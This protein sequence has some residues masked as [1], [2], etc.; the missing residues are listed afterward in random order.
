MPD[1]FSLYSPDICSL[2]TW[3]SHSLEFTHLAQMPVVPM[4]SPC[5][6]V[7]STPP[8][9]HHPARPGVFQSP[10]HLTPPQPSPS[11][12]PFVSRGINFLPASMAECE[13][14]APPTYHG[15]QQTK[16]VQTPG[17]TLWEGELSY[18]FQFQP[19]L[20][21]N[22]DTNFLP[23]KI[24]LACLMSCA[25]TSGPISAG[26]RRSYLCGW[27]VWQDNP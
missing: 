14:S 23:K 3:T 17:P 10:S 12:S 25:D 13:F 6:C 5:S 26:R 27:G 21:L 9:T 8:Q 22:L 18:K 19:L 4:S 11:L 7:I 24:W 2:S 1:F 15:S 16:I 20:P